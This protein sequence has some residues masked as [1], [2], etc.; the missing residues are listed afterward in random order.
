MTDLKQQVV[1]AEKRLIDKES[2]SEEVFGKLI[3][4]LTSKND[5]YPLYSCN[6]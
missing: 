5:R 1:V 2:E 3:E 4:E 6:D